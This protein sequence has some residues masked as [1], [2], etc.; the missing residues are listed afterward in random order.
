MS[1]SEG[2][3][4]KVVVSPNGVEVEMLLSRLGPTRYRLEDLM[5]LVVWL[6]ADIPEEAG[7][8]WLLEAEELEDGRLRLVR[9]FPDESIRV[10]SGQALPY[11][12]SESPQFRSFVECI[13]GLNGSWE[14]VAGGIFSAFVPKDAAAAR[15]FDLQGSMEHALSEWQRSVR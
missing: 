15:E 3:E 10:L 13:V 14:L 4:L 7:Y 6:D 9:L 5:G 11:G 8:G 12:F 2:E 1:P